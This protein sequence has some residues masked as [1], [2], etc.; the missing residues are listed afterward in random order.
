MQFNINRFYSYYTNPRNLQIDPNPPTHQFYHGKK[1]NPSP[2]TG[3]YITILGKRIYVE[4]KNSRIKEILFTIH[5]P[6]D[7]YNLDNHFH[8]GIRSKFT[9]NSRGIFYPISVIFFHKTIQNIRESK[10]DHKNCYFLLNTDINHI[11]D[12]DCVETEFDKMKTRFP[13]GSE[14]LEIIKRIIQIPFGI[15]PT[16]GGKRSKTRK[17]KKYMRKTRRIH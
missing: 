3:N 1:L 17:N 14:D 16:S 13:V 12:I 10:K 5:D 4:P 11:E 6:S 15:P 9:N 2:K 8:F 7:R